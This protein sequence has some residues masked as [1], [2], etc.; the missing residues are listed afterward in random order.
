MINLSNEFFMIGKNDGPY[1]C[2]FAFIIWYYSASDYP[3]Y[4][5]IWFGKL[6][7]VTL[8]ISAVISLLGIYLCMI[9]L[10]MSEPKKR[11]RYYLSISLVLFVWLLYINEFMQFSCNEYQYLLKKL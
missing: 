8:V 4:T 11:L 2:L 9:N 3:T 6:T 10:K 7:F 1:V 5:P